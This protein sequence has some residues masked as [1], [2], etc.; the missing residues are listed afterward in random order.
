VRYYVTPSKDT[1]WTVVPEVPGVG[2]ED[3]P[4]REEAIA[5]CRR[6][7]GEEI[8]AYRRL[9]HPLQVSPSE[10]FIDWTLP[11]WLI[12]D[13]LV[14]T[15]PGLV[16][17]AV[18]RMDELAAELDRFLDGLAPEEWDRVAGDGWSVRRTLDHVA[19]G[20]GIGLRR[21]E[22]WLLDPDEAQAHA[23][24]ELVERVRDA[25]LD[26]VEHVGMNTEKGR[27]RWTPAKVV[28]VVDA[29]QSAWR[30][31]LR[32][33]APEPAIPLGHDDSPYDDDPVP[34]QKLED[35]IRADAVLRGLGRTNPRMRAIAISYRYYRDRLVRW[36]KAERDRFHAIRYAFQRSLLQLS[37]SELALV[38]LAPNG[39]CDTVRMEL[40]LGLSHVIEHLEQMR[41]TI[42]R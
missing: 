33:V 1:W 24:A 25:S 2:A 42:A 3:A 14:P 39:Q 23:I 35:L 13:S 8:E 30:E 7:T 28:R 41:R 6:R 34:R 21:L 22:P 37:E 20:F 5:R 17:A 31:H 19:G 10:E 12:P 9:G 32:G 38:R 40:G 15:A 16:G 27:V 11:W 36:P 29:L 4:S 18:R 26:A